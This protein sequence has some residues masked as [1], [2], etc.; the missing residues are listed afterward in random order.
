MKVNVLF[1][2]VTA[3]IVGKREIELPLQTPIRSGEVFR[4][5]TDRYPQL[6]EHRLLF[7][8]NQEYSSGNEM[9]ND[10][11]ELAVFNAVSGG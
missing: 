2:G 4:Q 9:V 11:D 5:I 6:N 7:A 10:G 1:F 3:D 8:F